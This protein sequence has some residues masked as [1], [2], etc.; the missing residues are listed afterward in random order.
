MTKDPVRAMSIDEKKAAA[1]VFQ[2]KT[3]KYGKA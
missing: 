3:A 1:A 2:S